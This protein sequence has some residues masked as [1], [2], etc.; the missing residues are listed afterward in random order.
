MNLYMSDPTPRTLGKNYCFWYN[1]NNR[2][3][4]VIGP[5]WPFSIILILIIDIGLGYF[6]KTMD[7]S[8]NT[9]IFWIGLIL[10][11]LENI[12]FLWTVV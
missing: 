2:P 4:I 9:V 5:D 8:N 12:S 10:L 7:Y 6:L 3:R 1:N 11:L